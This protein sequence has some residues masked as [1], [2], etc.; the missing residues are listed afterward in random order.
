M[1]PHPKLQVLLDMPADPDAT[2]VEEM[3]PD[4]ARADF[5]AALGSVDGEKPE[6]HA[7]RDIEVPEGATVPPFYLVKVKAS[8]KAKPAKEG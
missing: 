1:Q 7:V 8:K 4:V 2:P 6:I 3:A 5:N